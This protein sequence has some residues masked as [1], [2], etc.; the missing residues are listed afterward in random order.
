MNE[1]KL[2]E[3]SACTYSL[4]IKQLP[5]PI[6]FESTSVKDALNMLKAQVTF[7]AIKSA[8]RKYLK[9]KK[10]TEDYDVD[11]LRDIGFI[12]NELSDID[13]GNTSTL[14][15]TEVLE[16]YLDPKEITEFHRHAQQVTPSRFHTLGDSTQ[17]CA[18]FKLLPVFLFETAARIAEALN[19]TTTDIDF[20]EGRVTIR[21]GKRGKTRYVHIDQS[22]SLLQNHISRFD[23]DGELFLFD[24]ETEYWKIRYEMIRIGNHDD[25]K[26]GDVTPHWFRHSYATDWCIKEL[27]KGRGKAEVKEEIRNFLGHEDTSTTEAYIHAA[28]ELTKKN[29]YREHGGFN[30]EL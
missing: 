3:S 29:I 12:Q 14:T 5:E 16:K 1:A 22:L 18:E 30:L 13:A 4:Y 27:K 23:I 15:K 7:P 24:R 9:F 26:F 21:R 19:V 8:Y 10:K 25:L 20:E 2:A 17:K 6:D 28:E 11:T